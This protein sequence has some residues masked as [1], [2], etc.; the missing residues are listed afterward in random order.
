MDR[1]ARRA[2]GCPRL[3]CCTTPSSWPLYASCWPLL[4][5][6]LTPGLFWAS[7]VSVVLLS[8]PLPTSLLVSRHGQYHLGSLPASSVAGLRP[9]TTRY[10]PSPNH[11]LPRATTGN[12][13]S[14]NHRLPPATTQYHRLPPRV[15]FG[16]RR[17]PRIREC[18]TASCHLPP[19]GRYVL[20][21]GAYPPWPVLSVW[22]F[23]HGGTA[24]S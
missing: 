20:G 22:G 13:L 6:A 24:D 4:L 8:P 2:R 3:S 18:V 19:V 5:Y 11:R 21:T 16:N 7:C 23:L 17:R 1:L 9:A 12:P 14:P 15:I 10:P